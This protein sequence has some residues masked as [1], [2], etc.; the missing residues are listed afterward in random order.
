MIRRLA[1]ACVG[2]WLAAST[3]AAQGEPC[4]VVITG[5]ARGADTTRIQRITVPGGGRHTY[6]GGGVDA[7]CAG[8]GNRLL[9]DSAEHF[10]DRGVLILYHNVRYS[11]P[12]M[13]MTSDRMFYYTNDE[14]LVADGNVRGRTSSGTRF[15]GPQFEYFRA[16]P[17]LRDVPYWI[18]VGR[19]F[20]RMSPADANARAADPNDPSTAPDSVDIT[21]NRIVSRN[22]SLVWASGAVVIERADMVSTADSAMVDNGIEFAR[23]MR[24]P[25]V[26]GKGARPFTL[27][28][29][30]IDVWSER[31]A[32]ARVLADSA[33]TA[34]SDSLTLTGE[35]IDIRFADQAIHRVYVWG[36]RAN[37][38]APEQALD[39]DSLDILM[40]GQR[41]QE[42]R[43]IGT[44]RAL[45]RV[46][47]ARIVT[48]ERDWIAGDTVI[49]R[50]EAVTDSAATERTRMREVTATGAARAFYQVAQS[51][52]DRGAPNLSYNRGRMITVL[53]VDGEM[54]TVTVTERASGLY[55]EKD[56]P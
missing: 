49:A 13:S 28:G 55:L 45:S 35:H 32:L 38:D 22:D 14:R 10:A 4:E 3:A 44:A 33:A 19:P 26:V 9:A 8:Q 5:V 17:G 46:D 6:I 37:A 18:A 12:R 20:V 24:Q 43:A 1:G 53:F 23:L 56:R 48:T 29:Q 52:V 7:T 42:V 2:V 15:T 39:A 50:F 31:R 25:K 11:E 51:G 47:T 16:K 41:L 21:A 36:G 40:P 27:V 30:V 54:S 34:T